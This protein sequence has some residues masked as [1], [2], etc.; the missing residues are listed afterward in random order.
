MLESY[1][2]LHGNVFKFCQFPVDNSALSEQVLEELENIDDEA[3]DSDIQFVRTDDR[4][5]Q[6]DWGIDDT[7]AVVFFKNKIPNV[8]DGDLRDETAVLKWLIHQKDNDE[9][10]DVTAEMLDRLIRD[11]KHLAVLFCKLLCYLFSGAS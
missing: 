11:S 8:Y 5:A 3:G 9:I 10:E 6:K 1:S 7:P 4:K 2:N